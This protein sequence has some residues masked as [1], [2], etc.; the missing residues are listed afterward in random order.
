MVSA[1]AAMAVT[2]QLNQ[3]AAATRSSNF[4]SHVKLTGGCTVSATPLEFGT[5]GAITGTE[6]ATANVSVNCTAGTLYVV[7]LP[8]GSGAMTGVT[9]PAEKVNY[10]ATMPTTF[11]ISTGVPRIFPISGAIAVQATPS[12]Q[13]Y[14]EVRTVNLFF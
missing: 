11:A 5:I 7:F 4:N 14:V 1:L 9:N 12:Q 3:V 6:T 2:E 13:D 10:T 8:N